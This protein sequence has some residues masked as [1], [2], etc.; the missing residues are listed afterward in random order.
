MFDLVV[1]SNNEGKVREILPLAVNLRLLRLVDI[2]FTEEIAEPY[3]TFEEN[4]N[5]KASTVYEFCRKNTFAEDSGICVNALGG[6]PGVVSAHYSGS[7][8]DE[9]NLLQVL[10]EMEGIENRSAYYKAVICLYWDGTPHYFE[11]VCPGFITREKKGS[12]GFGYDP[13]FIPEGYNVTFGELPLE[14]KN[15]ISHRAQ[16]LQKMMQFIRLAQQ[17]EL[18]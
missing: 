17:D 5:A 16:A 18:A 13:I 3:F 11:G 12:G 4:A 8:N 2:G 15:R 14:V 7:R 1:A 6:K 9:L 10:D